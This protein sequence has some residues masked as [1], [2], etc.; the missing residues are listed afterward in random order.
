[1]LHYRNLEDVAVEQLASISTDLLVIA[2]INNGKMVISFALYSKQLCPDLRI[3]I[4][5]DTAH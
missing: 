2:V 1:V 5:A 4:L 3:V